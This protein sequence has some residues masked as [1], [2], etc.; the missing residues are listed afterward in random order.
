[1]ADSCDVNIREQASLSYCFSKEKTNQSS[2]KASISSS[3]W[4]VVERVEKSDRDASWKLIKLRGG[5]PVVPNTFGKYI[6]FVLEP[7]QRD[8]PEDFRDNFICGS[9]AKKNE[10]AFCDR[11]AS[12]NLNCRTSEG[13]PEKGRGIMMQWP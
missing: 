2:Q 8:V 11:S 9:C 3:R 12:M 10:K 5:R 1:M 7:S 13:I 4:C 6:Q